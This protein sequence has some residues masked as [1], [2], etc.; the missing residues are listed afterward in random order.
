MREVKSIN[1]GNNAGFRL[2]M[3][4]LGTRL[5]EADKKGNVTAWGACSSRP[6]LEPHLLLSSC[7]TI[8]TQVDFLLSFERSMI[9]SFST[10]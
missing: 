2:S 9:A 7:C 3:I 4:F 10:N 1:F 6:P 8:I 5:S